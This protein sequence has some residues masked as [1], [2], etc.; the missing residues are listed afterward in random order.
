MG[1][2]ETL[3]AQMESEYAK[4]AFGTRVCGTIYPSMR[5]FLIVASAIASAR[6]VP[7]DGQAR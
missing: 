6:S 5:V 1:M 4:W 7:A 3:L 2:F